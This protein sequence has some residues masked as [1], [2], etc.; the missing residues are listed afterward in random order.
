LS[1]LIKWFK[2]R[3]ETKAIEDIQRHLDLVT[4]VVEDLEKAVIAAIKNEEEEMQKCIERLANREEEADSL[5]RAIMGEISKGELLPAAREDLMDLVK[6]LDMVADWSRDS[7]RVLAAL[8]M[9][10]IPKSIKDEFVEM[11]KSVKKCAVSLQVC[12]NKVMTKPDEALKAADDV[13]REEEK[14][15]EIH[16]KARKLLGK[17]DLPKAGVAVLVNQLF[18][19]MEM[20]S[21]SCEDACDQIRVILVRK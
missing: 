4:S 21:D 15:D 9:E 11:I 1:E 16:G 3:R 12:M 2:K 14:V 5:R 19:T 13:E 17:T 7:A 6:R 10:H 18:E 20:I 8:P